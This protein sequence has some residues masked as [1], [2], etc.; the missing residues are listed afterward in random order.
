[1]K[2]L[3]LIC[4]LFFINVALAAQQDS[5]F[6]QWDKRYGGILVDYIMSS[7]PTSDGGYLLGGE[8]YSGIG[9][10]KS[11]DN[12]DTS[13]NT[14]DYW[15]VKIDQ[16]GNKQWEKRFGGYS[17]D[18]TLFSL[19]QT[20]DGGYLLCGTS[21]SG[22]GGDKTQ[23]SQGGDDYWIVKIDSAGNKQWD[24]RYGGLGGDYVY[25]ALITSDG[26]Y[27]FGGQTYSPQSG[28]V[29]QP[30]RG[31]VDYWVIKTDSVGNKQW[32]A[33]FG[34]SRE[35][36]LSALIQTNDG[37]YL[38]GGDSNSD[39]SGDKT[40]N[41]YNSEDY[42]YWIVKIDSVGNKLWDKI[43]GSN[44]AD[45]FVT[46]TKTSDGNFLL[47]GYSY[48]TIGY[49]KTSPNC[50][51]NGITLDCWIVKIDSAGNKLW[52]KDYGGSADD[53]LISLV[54][55]K[56]GGFLLT[57]ASSSP[58]SC[59]KS[60]NN[61]T[62][63]PDYPWLVKI[64]SAGNKQWDKTIFVNDGAVPSNAFQT[65]DGSYIVAAFT[66]SE[67]GYY[68]S[69][70]S[71]DSSTDYWVIKFHDTT[72]VNGIQEIATN[73]HFN[74]YPNPFST[75]LDI[76]LAAPNLTTADFQ[77]CN[78]SGQTVYSRHETNLSPAYTKMLDLSYLPN[79]VYLVEVVVDGGV[80]VREVV[81]Q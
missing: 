73:L 47:G 75:E 29:S 28:D 76:A 12:W 4:C 33:R 6:K 50:S 44:S 23:N 43:Y 18:G 64:D 32:D 20:A 58:A 71:W 16:S 9:G 53:A 60:E 24:K 57:S 79:G 22:I 61:I 65:K 25:A 34:G 30:A 39:S 26:G 10:D 55:T 41:A 49:D 69:Q 21:G 63:G 37:G 45:Y 56:D 68:K 74:A 3:I 67:V 31:Y 38:L 5:L 14:V 15:V 42:T 8:S 11:Q 59:Q 27:I 81:K 66:S 2:S 48:G 54:T 78:I 7:I 36:F 40:Q 51:P 80:T 17:D 52:D 72:I 46:L 77:I 70:P 62:T 35:N 13:Y 19:V 1:M